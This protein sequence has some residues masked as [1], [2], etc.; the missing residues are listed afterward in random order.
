M[1]DTLLSTTRF[2]EELFLGAMLQNDYVALQLAALFSNVGFDRESFKHM[3][4]NDFLSYMLNQAHALS[5][6]NSSIDI[7]SPL[8]GIILMCRS[9]CD[10]NSRG[11]TTELSVSEILD[12]SK[13]FLVPKGGL[14]ST[15]KT[16]RTAIRSRLQEPKELLKTLIEETTKEIDL[17]SLLTG[18]GVGERAM[19]RIIKKKGFS[20]VEALNVLNEGVN[21]L[22]SV[23]VLKRECQQHSV[24]CWRSV[25]VFKDD[26][27]P[28]T[29]MTPYVFSQRILSLFHLCMQQGSLKEIHESY[30]LKKLEDFNRGSNIHNQFSSEDFSA[31]LSERYFDVSKFGFVLHGDV[32]NVIT[33]SPGNPL[34]VAAFVSTIPWKRK[35]EWENVLCFSDVV[36]PHDSDK[37]LTM[38]SIYE[39]VESSRDE[40]IDMPQIAKEN[41]QSVWFASGANSQR[42]A[43]RA[44]YRIFDT[45]ANM[46]SIGYDLTD[47]VVDMNDAVDGVLLSYMVSRCPSRI[48]FCSKS[49]IYLEINAFGFAKKHDLQLVDRFKVFGK[50][51]KLLQSEYHDVSAF[52]LNA[53]L[54]PKN[55]ESHVQN[56]NALMKINA[57]NEYLDEKTESIYHGFS[58]EAIYEAKCSV[59]GKS[60][61]SDNKTECRSC[62][63]NVEMDRFLKSTLSDNSV[64]VT[65]PSNAYR[66]NMHIAISMF[67][68]ADSE[69]TGSDSL[70]VL[71]EVVSSANILRNSTMIKQEVS[72][73]SLRRYS[74][75]NQARRR[76][77]WDVEKA[78]VS[79]VNLPS[80]TEYLVLYP[81]SPVRSRKGTFES[82]RESIE[83]TDTDYSDQS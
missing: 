5:F 78:T 32:N 25:Y 79:P 64:I 67:P 52:Y 38:Q 68:I 51:E 42:N 6:M 62:N 72:P 65:K 61:G 76:V 12:I 75:L 17:D 54:L 16:E 13:G 53:C 50:V 83:G 40:R 34:A 26:N 59:C 30:S 18:Y 48:H 14:D 37:P 15:S 71:N 31:I 46:S 58:T 49:S 22:R 19:L 56:G 27:Y 73:D 29:L 69:F 21:V 35:P 8:S 43:F 24:G 81:V 3:K 2:P 1:T 44:A 47:I 80:S 45:Y 60:L 4:S 7:D 41:V 39:V 55:Y 36:T 10:L 20:N 74:E 70:R 77:Y 11:I 9:L 82:E 63:V 23:K 28:V 66:H 33:V 57:F